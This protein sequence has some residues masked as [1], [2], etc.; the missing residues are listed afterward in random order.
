MNILGLTN[1]NT[2]REEEITNTRTLCLKILG[3]C[4]RESLRLLPKGD[5]LTSDITKTR[6][7]DGWPFDAA[8]CAEQSFRQDLL[9]GHPDHSVA[10]RLDDSWSMLLK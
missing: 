9:A 4:V 7:Q 2:K 6:P 1:N 3:S 10:Q 5:D 8:I